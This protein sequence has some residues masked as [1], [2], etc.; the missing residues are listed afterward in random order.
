MTFLKILIWI[1]VIL[2]IIIAGGSLLLPKSYAVN[3]SIVIQ[4]PDSV[5]YKNIGDFQEFF[6][7]SPWSKMDPSAKITITGEP[8]RPGHLYEWDG[9]K[10]GSGT[11]KV[12]K[13]DPN[14]MVDIELKF[15]KPMES[16]ADTRFDIVPEGTGNKITWTMSGESKGVISKWFGFFMDKMIGKDFESGLKSLKDKSE[17]G[18]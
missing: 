18:S 13:T 5:I 2:V 4:A 6:K 16:T 17:K 7:W 1:I 15:I 14:K 11:M 3:R 8:A 10:N 12:I 9:K